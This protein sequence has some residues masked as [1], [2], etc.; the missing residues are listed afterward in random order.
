MKFSLEIQCR[1][2]ALTVKGFFF[3]SVRGDMSSP[4]MP[5]MVDIHYV[6][7]SGED[8]YLLTEPIHTEIEE[9]I[10]ETIEQ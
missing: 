8:I 5:A 3:P 9:L 1:G 10:I 2:T 7:H 6:K 4:D